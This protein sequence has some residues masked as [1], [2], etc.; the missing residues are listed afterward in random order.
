MRDFRLGRPVPR[1]EDTRLLRGG[2]RYTD[3]IPSPNV[4][5]LYLLRSP[6]AAAKIRNI[7]LA[8]ARAAAGAISVFSGIDA[9]RDGLGSFASFV[10]RNRPDGSSFV[11]PY[12]VLA[13]DQVQHVGDPVVAIVAETIEQAKDAAELVI[14]DYETLPAVVDT[15]SAASPG[16]P[17][18]WDEAPDNICFV[19]QLGDRRPSTLSLRKQTTSSTRRFGSAASS[20]TLW[21][22]RGY[23]K[24]RSRTRSLHPV[25]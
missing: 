12:R 16:Q 22:P 19:F 4:A 10:P 8:A 3:D 5:H 20:P 2:G 9:L 17:A 1:T 6:H 21:R 24:L 11:P 18:V 7:D 14:V 25:R 23:W 15:A 13:V